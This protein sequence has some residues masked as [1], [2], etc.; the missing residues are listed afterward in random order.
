MT[1]NVPW[2]QLTLIMTRCALLARL[3]IV[4]APMNLPVK[5]LCVA[6]CGALYVLY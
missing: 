1:L 3:D 4:K 6:I 5:S 2:L